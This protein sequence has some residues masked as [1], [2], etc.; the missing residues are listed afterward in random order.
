MGVIKEDQNTRSYIFWSI[1][2]GIVILS[3]LILKSLLISI[4]TAIIIAHI[5]R[6]LHKKLS[7]KLNQKFA[8]FITVMLI[9]IGLLTMFI[10][11]TTIFI[12][13][14]IKFLSVDNIAQ[15]TNLISTYFESELINEKLRI[16]IID[17]GNSVTKL[18]T[19]KIL[20]I[21]TIL[22]HLFII[23][24]TTYYLLID[25]DRLKEKV[26]LIIPFK[27]SREIIKK[28]ERRTSEIISGTLFIAG[29]Q[30]VFSGIF[31]WAIGVQAYLVLAILIGILAFIPGLGPAIV[32]A[33]LAAFHYFYGNLGIAIGVIIMGAIL[34]LI[35]DSLLRAKILGSR[36]GTHPAIILF[37]IVGGI[38]LF[39]II[40]LIIGPLILII[41]TTI[42]ESIPK[43]RAG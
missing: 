34:S 14:L 4:L 29:V 43:E 37:G 17:V 32:W 20:E 12:N 1:I 22:F 35:L 24:F 15:L 19:S 3:Y 9:V 8:A 21:P 28:I 40:G 27:N 30:L 39:G 38:K 41:F 18:V 6:P 5:S 42:L 33:P 10:F 23:F 2:I 36:T 31:M 16:A 25:W 11:F 7:K 13:Q 26:V